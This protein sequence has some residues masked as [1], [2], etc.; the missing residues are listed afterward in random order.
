MRAFFMPLLLAA[1]IAPG[2]AQSV[3][4]SDGLTAKKRSPF[5]LH[6][7]VT[8]AEERNVDLRLAREELAA[9]EGRARQ[10]AVHPNPSL[11]W[12][13]EGKPS[14]GGATSVQLAIP[15]ELGG[16]RAARREVAEME[17]SA[18][19]VQLETVRSSVIADVVAQYSDAYLAQQFLETAD[20]MSA[21]AALSTTAASKRV[22]AGKISPVEEARAKVA[23][24]N[25][26]IEAIQAQ[27][28]L[29]DARA[30]LSVLV[31][32]SASDLGSL[33]PPA[34]ELPAA[35][36]MPELEQRLAGAPALLHALDEYR[37]RLAN[38][39]LQ[40]TARVPDVSII[41]GQRREGMQR[42]RQNVVGLSLPLPL[43]DR[44]QGAIIEA[45]RRADKAALEVE[46]ARFKVRAE[47]IAA[48]ARLVAAL[49]QERL[50]RLDVLPSA[51]F[52]AE[53]AAKG[54]E[55]GKF[56]YLEVLD[57]QRTYYEAQSQHL[58]AL[59][60]AHRSY[61]DLTKI[62]GKIPTSGTAAQD[63]K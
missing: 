22:A 15:I 16:K 24:S 9:L 29:A 36:T 34:H 37:V 55:A 60:N 45:D 51:S 57:A 41:V 6:M 7:A 11:E 10:A 39:R 62:V 26:K 47:A 2:V 46:G 49:E 44:N 17:L 4:A 8:L 23:E 48:Q 59:S 18:A 31:G 33:A 21:S 50:I 52:A 12:V 43:F 58:Q 13:R 38:A 27:A 25:L 28:K 40:R 5:S 53:A 1:C 14:Q 20:A 30:K 61:A 19:K 32:I 54:F 42:E 56:S 63:T 3:F 35:P